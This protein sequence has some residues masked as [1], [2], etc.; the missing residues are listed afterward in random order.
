[1]LHIARIGLTVAACNSAPPPSELP[2]AVDPPSVAMRHAVVVLHGIASAPSE[3]GHLVLPALHHWHPVWDVPS[4]PSGVNLQQRQ[5]FNSSGPLLRSPQA[6]G[7]AAPPKR[8]STGALLFG[9]E[10][11]RSSSNKKALQC[12]SMCLAAL[13]QTHAETRG[14]EWVGIHCIREGDIAGIRHLRHIQIC[15]TGVPPPRR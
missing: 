11:R 15:L 14:E 1:M 9:R 4:L 13:H 2:C 8:G 12:C 10:R 3:G 5:V 7:L 6:K